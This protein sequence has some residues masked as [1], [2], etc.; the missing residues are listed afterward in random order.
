MQPVFLLVKIRK[1]QNT[2]SVFYLFFYLINSYSKMSLCTPSPEI[3]SL[4]LYQLIMR[5][6]FGNSSLI[7]YIYIITVSDS[8]QSVSYNNAG[9]IFGQA[10]NGFLDT[11]FCNRIKI[12][13]CFVHNENIRFS[14]QG[15]P[16]QTDRDFLSAR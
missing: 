6:L 11:L 14:E 12:T 15:K 4:F 1:R 7:H 2:L 10:L 16:N 9:H 13:R 3:N 5:T 8:I